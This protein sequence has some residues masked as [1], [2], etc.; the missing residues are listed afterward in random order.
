MN[1]NQPS[2]RIS[3][4]YSAAFLFAQGMELIGIDNSNHRRAEFVFTNPGKCELL[5]R[6]YSF[7]QDGSAETLVDARKFSTAIKLLKEKLYQE[8][9]NQ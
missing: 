7:A 8:K 1:D 2:F 3:N 6:S 5:V 4:F 9:A